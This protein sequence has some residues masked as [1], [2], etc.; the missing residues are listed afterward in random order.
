MAARAC[1]AAGIRR[2]QEH[3]EHTISSLLLKGVV[4]VVVK[5]RGESGG[6][7]G[8]YGGHVT[9]VGMRLRQLQ[10]SSG[11]RSAMRQRSLLQRFLAAKL[12]TLH[13]TSVYQPFSSCRV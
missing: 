9:L 11:C 8:G 6:A 12:Q 2:R 5:G 3:A 7:T 13:S 10:L 4:D 1:D